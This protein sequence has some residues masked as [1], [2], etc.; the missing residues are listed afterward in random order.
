MPIRRTP[1]KGAAPELEAVGGFSVLA[2]SCLLTWVWTLLPS[3]CVALMSVLVL[4]LLVG[5]LAC[6]VPVLWCCPVFVPSLLLLSFVVV[7]LSVVVVLLVCLLLL[8]LLLFF[9]GG[10]SRINKTYS[11]PY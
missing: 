4:G 7:W 10:G 8:L 3:V 2:P 6:G 9:L 1:R 5:V 11:T